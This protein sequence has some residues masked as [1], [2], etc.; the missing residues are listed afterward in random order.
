MYQSTFIFILTITFPLLSVFARPQYAAK[1]QVSC[2]ECHV[3]P[4]GGGHRKVFGKKYGTKDFKGSVHNQNDLFYGDLTAMFF[5]PTDRSSRSI[6][7]GPAIMNAQV[8]AYVP[9]IEPQEDEGEYKVS[10]LAGYD[11]GDLATGKREL[12]IIS[13]YLGDDWYKPSSF[14]FG[15]TYLP[16]GIIHDEH[17]T[18]TRLQSYTG[19]RNY[20]LAA[21]AS[22]DLLNSLLHV[23]LGVMEGFSS[24]RP[25]DL[26]IDQNKTVGYVTNIRYAPNNFPLL[27]GASYLKH[28][29]LAKGGVD[30]YAYSSYLVVAFDKII[31]WFKASL[32]G[33]VVWSKHMESVSTQNIGTYFFDPTS[34]EGLNYFN[35]IKGK[36]STGHLGEF[37]WDLTPQLVLI[38]KYDRLIFDHSYNQDAYVRL[39]P[40]IR[41]QING[42]SYFSFRYETEKN[43][44]RFS[45][46]ED[47]LANIDNIIATY[48]IWL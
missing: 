1:E 6:N 37:R 30:P 9:V 46:N 16:F 4:W 45:T 24:L 38:F 21:I 34:G 20:E 47:S 35:A 31:P 23:D 14:V 22:Y 26:R 25:Q 28:D 27:L 2:I 8:S 18:Y 44:L 11:L 15:R 12:S 41:Y 7:S 19:T 40:G 10:I 42:H 36:T 13:E 39:G 33:E 43:K 32:M 5:T 3:T 17:R 29:N 48:Q